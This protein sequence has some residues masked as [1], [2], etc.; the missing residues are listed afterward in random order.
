MKNFMDKGTKCLLVH[1]KCSTN[2][3]WNYVEVC[4]IV[5]A[6]YPAAPLGLMTAAALLP[7]QW[8]FKLIDTNV[9]PLLDE[10]LKWA[11]IVGT[12]GMLPQ[13]SGTLS[14][15]ERAHKFGCPVIVGGPDP[16]SQPNLYQSSDYLVLGEGEISIPMFI[17][18]LKK[19]C[20]S[21]EFKSDE[22]AEMTRAVIPRFDLIRFRDYIQVGIQCTRGCPF[23]C[24]FCDVI[25]MYGRK[26]RSKS[27]EQIINEM[28]TLYDLGYRGHIDF[29][30]DNFIV[31]KKNTREVLLAIKEWSEIHNYPYYFSTE[32]SINLANDENLLQMMKDVDFRYVF[33]GIESPDNEVLK[34]AQKPLNVNADL[35]KTVKKLNSY[36]MIVNAGFIIG[37]DHE[38]KDTSENMIKFIQ[39]SGICMAMLGKLYALPNTQLTRR[40]HKE[41]R[42]FEE[43]SILRNINTEIDQLTSGLNFITVRPRIDILKDYVRIINY[44]YN[45]KHYY[46]RIITTGLNLRP[47]NKYKPGIANILKSIKAF[48]KLCKKVGFNKT[49]GWLYWKMFMKIIFKN[50][51][52][53]EATVNLAAMFIHFHNQS[54]FIIELTIT[55]IKNIENYG[56]DKYNKLM[57][58]TE[59]NSN[60]HKEPLPSI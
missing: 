29:V 42:L 54:E 24:E 18:A 39:E 21:G 6:K 55:E 58:Q 37:F 31:N 38:S 43:G 40:L 1:P 26:P 9:T 41:G 50:P 36:G 45:P 60:R 52:A 56:E 48:L 2:S 27:P 49:T 35:V 20:T 57:L 3:Y 25:E 46:E 28:Q 16:S 23:N 11:D 5:G 32:A 51:K 30:D 34:L 53:I 15:I 10:H 59:I 33:I 19:G 13:Q 8:Q 47:A 22:K 44:I 12:G 17:Q 14:I 7:Q 4:K